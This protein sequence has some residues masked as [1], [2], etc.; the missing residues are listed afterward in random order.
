MVV[1]DMAVSPFYTCCGSVVDSWSIHQLRLSCYCQHIKQSVIEVRL[2]GLFME[3]WQHTNKTPGASRRRSIDGLHTSHWINVSLT[4]VHRLR[5]WTNVKPHW[6]YVLCLLGYVHMLGQ[7]QCDVGS[8]FNW[9]LIMGDLQVFWAM[10]RSFAW[11][12]VKFN[13]PVV[14]AWRELHGSTSEMDSIAKAVFFYAGGQCT[15]GPKKSWKM[16][17]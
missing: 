9:C 5:R 12:S 8:I 17:G 3:I 15:L 16:W 11:S 13:I 2:P 10:C 14:R 1:F 4:L 6:F 7:R